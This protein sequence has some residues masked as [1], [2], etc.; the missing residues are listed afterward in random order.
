M[1]SANTENTSSTLLETIGVTIKSVKEGVVQKGQL[2]MNDK[3]RTWLRPLFGLALTLSTFFW[4]F[5]FRFI[6]FPFLV[7]TWAFFF[8]FGSR[9]LRASLA[10][11]AV[12]LL[13]CFSPIDVLPIP[14]GGH[15][16]LVP[17]VMGLP[18]PETVQ[19]AK[20]GEVI[21]GGCIVSGFEPKYYLVW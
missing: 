3:A 20:R 12:C 4:F 14:K 15:P 5:A 8:K 17:L 11:W 6:A 19:R 9:D 16:R 18:K 1:T 2:G 21:L 10:L 7:A 13:L